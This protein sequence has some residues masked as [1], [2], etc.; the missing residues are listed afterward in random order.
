MM[1]YIY[2]QITTAV[3]YTMQCGHT[4]FPFA[5]TACKI[6]SRWTSRILYQRRSRWQHTPRSGR[7]SNCRHLIQFIY[8]NCCIAFYHILTSIFFYKFKVAFACKFT[9][10]IWK[11]NHQSMLMTSWWQYEP[12]KLTNY[13]Y[14]FC[15]RVDKLRF[16]HTNISLF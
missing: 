14:S 16:W 3:E 15:E 10:S 4:F 12:W 13:C 7:S 9:Y 1:T 11:N 6:L 2:Y 5:V 8:P